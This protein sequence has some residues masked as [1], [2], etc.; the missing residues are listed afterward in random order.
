MKKTKVII[1][2]RAT[3]SFK[4]IIGD[5]KEISLIG[6][7]DARAAILNR[8]RKIG[9][10]PMANSDKANFARLD[11]EYRKADVWDYRIYY[12]VED[13]QAI[14]LDII[15]LQIKKKKA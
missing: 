5:L 9:V 6:G 14:V 11:G 7:E 12:K 15:T 8:I 3:A 1:T 4:R 10:N 2:D 13:T